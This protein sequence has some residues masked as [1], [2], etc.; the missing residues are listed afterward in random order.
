[1]KIVVLGLGAIGSNLLVQLVRQYPDIEYEGVD[2]DRVE[3]RNIGPQAYFRELVNAPKAVA[4]QAVLS[5]FNNVKYTP[6]V[7][8]LE[9]IL[10]PE[11]DTVY[12]DCFDNSASRRLTCVRGE[13]FHVGFSPQYTAEGIWSPQYDPAGDVPAESA[14][15]CTLTG[16]IPFIHTVVNT[17]AFVI[18]GFIT[19]G[20]KNN[21]ILRG[22]PET[23]QFKLDYL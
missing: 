21:F 12:L 17:A 4:I 13:I 22:N 2:F 3:P 14:D 10:V 16:A 20:R 5:R 8:K 23:S 9:K 7:F 15:I 1:M 6:K 11:K 18:S 19:A